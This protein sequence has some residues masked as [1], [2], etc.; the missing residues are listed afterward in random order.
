MKILW[1]ADADIDASSLETIDK[2]TREAAKAGGVKVDG[3]YLPQDAALLYVFEAESLAAFNAAGR[4][5][6]ELAAKAGV[7]ASPLR[8]EIALSPK[9][10]W[11]K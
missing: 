7:E 11:G 9:E 2:L 10:F 3:P 8:Y 4:K 1:K 6:F 5:W